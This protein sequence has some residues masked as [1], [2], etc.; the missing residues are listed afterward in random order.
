MKELLTALQAARAEI[1]K[2]KV[3]KEGKN[4]FSKYS[5]FTP[6]QVEKLVFDACNN[7]GIV[8]KFDL[9]EVNDKL[10]GVL[11]VYHIESG[12]VL[13]FV[14][15]TAIPDIMATNAAQQLGGAMTYTHRYL[16]Q[17]AFGIAENS[18]DFDAQEPK[19]TPPKK[20][21]KKKVTKDYPT[22]N[23]MK[24]A[25]KEGKFTVATLQKK[26]EFDTY[27]LNILTSYEAES[28][29]KASGKA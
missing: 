17:S 19:K 22:F 1:K 27:T 21:E 6:E 25:V 11:T 3:K 2:T 15:L 9:D 29:R 14:M 13:T 7:N 5:Y 26:F 18:L 12:K 24:A 23:D 10:K 8:T 20:V 28:K 4:T 16:L